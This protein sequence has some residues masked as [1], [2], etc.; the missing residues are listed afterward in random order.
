MALNGRR[1]SSSE[2]DVWVVMASETITDID[3]LFSK[4]KTE[5]DIESVNTNQL[6]TD[7]QEQ[8]CQAHQSWKKKNN[9]QTKE[10]PDNEPNRPTN[11]STSA[12]DRV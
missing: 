2:Q 5:D 1:L 6:A 3:R 7:G 11:Q 12:I 8:G 4:R 10:Q 9:E